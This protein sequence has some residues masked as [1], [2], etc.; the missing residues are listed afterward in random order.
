MASPLDSVFQDVWVYCTLYSNFS[1]LLAH[2]PDYFYVY[3]AGP[4]AMQISR[5]TFSNSGSAMAASEKVL[6]IDPDGLQGQIYHFGGDL[7]F[8]PGE[9]TELFKSIVMSFL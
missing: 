9:W 2:P 4:N 8:G 3:Y 6:Y 1:S 7:S 5:F